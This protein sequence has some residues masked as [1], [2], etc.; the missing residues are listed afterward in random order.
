M[1]TT[2]A[3]T[4]YHFYLSVVCLL[5]VA[6]PS[7]SHAGHITGPWHGD[8][9]LEDMPAQAA[10]SS[11]IGTGI[12]AGDDLVVHSSFRKLS[13][14]D[15]A[16]ELL[17]P[18]AERTD[19]ALDQFKANL[20]KEEAAEQE[21]AAY[22]AAINA[23]A[24]TAT[25]QLT[26]AGAQQPERKEAKEEDEGLS[27]GIPP[28][29]PPGLTK[30]DNNGVVTHLG[31]LDS[32]YCSFGKVKEWK[33]DVLTTDG[34]KASVEARSFKKE[35]IVMAESRLNPFLQT[36]AEFRKLGMGH[37]MVVMPTEEKCDSMMLVLP[38][39][40]GCGWSSMD[41]GHKHS[42]RLQLDRIMY[43][44]RVLRL[45]INV[46]MV[47]TDVFIFRDPYVRFIFRDP[48]VFLKVPP[49]N[50]YHYMAMRDGNGYL[51]C[52]LVYVQNV[53]PGGATA[54]AI[55]DIID[56]VLRWKESGAMIQA[57]KSDRWGSNFKDGCWD[58]EIYMDT[59][60]SAIAGRLVLSPN[61]SEIS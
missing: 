29:V 16:A 25:G 26:G 22:V 54:Y 13:S 40:L 31:C 38:G 5:L 30:Y 27:P 18:Q 15:A 9:Y 34:L 39:E 53:D 28:G 60:M 46:L 37:V 2:P 48:Y 7:P 3:R 49:L 57:K 6:C 42:V 20:G 52:G 10:S 19:A 36:Y 41:W 43:M 8:A 32:G 59:L 17:K 47:D 45:G 44:G 23:A 50:Q 55:N 35:L 24:L 12:R 33:G 11:R 61:N 14:W 58:Q 1:S 4:S 56:R 21:K 51:N